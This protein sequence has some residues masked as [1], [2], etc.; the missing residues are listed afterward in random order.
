MEENKKT[1]SKYKI[2]YKNAV[3]KTAIFKLAE[4]SISKD[5]L[6][7]FMELSQLLKQVVNIEE[8]AICGFLV[9]AN[10]LMEKSGINIEFEKFNEVDL[11]EDDNIKELITYF[12][13][14]IVLALVNR[15]DI[16]QINESIDELLY[17]TSKIDT[18][19]LNN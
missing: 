14:V 3:I 11:L 19:I 18:N 17:D 1:R 4:S 15:V 5:A 10:E 2:E 13:R 16:F 12:K 7:V 9:I 6:E 8:Q